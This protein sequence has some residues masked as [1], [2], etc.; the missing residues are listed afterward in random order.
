MCT[1]KRADTS[2]DRRWGFFFQST[3]NVTVVQYFIIIT[4]LF[5]KHDPTDWSTVLQHFGDR[6]VSW[7]GFTKGDSGSDMPS[8]SR[9]RVRV[10]EK[11][12][13]PPGTGRFINAWLKLQLINFVKTSFYTFSF[14]LAY[15]F[16]LFYGTKHRVLSGFA[17]NRVLL[18]S[19]IANITY[20]KHLQK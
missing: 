17:E 20:I 15:L 19:Q 5:G 9:S 13:D 7:N 12:R 3:N 1:P 8:L 14:S 2:L 4:D 6:G 16:N 10:S 11:P 18:G